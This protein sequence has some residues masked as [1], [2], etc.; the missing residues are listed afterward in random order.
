MRGPAEADLRHTVGRGE[1]VRVVYRLGRCAASGVLTL[2]AATTRP[3]VFVLRRGGA[4]C[5]DGELA[6]RALGARLARCAAEPWLAASFEGG[7]AAYPPGAVNQLPLAGWARTHIEGRFDG[8]IAEALVR[9]LDGRRLTLRPELA[10]DPTDDADRRMLAAMAQPRRLDQI[11]PLARAPRFRMLGFLHLLR[12]VGA[13]DVEAPARVAS[14]TAGAGA[15]GAPASASTSRSTSA[16]TAGATRASTSRPTGGAPSASTSQATGASTGRPT[17]ASPGPPARGVDP[18][19][20]AAMRVLG[21]DGIADELDVKRAYRRLART[22]HPDLQPGADEQRRRVLERRFA[23][24]TA[25]YEA[26]V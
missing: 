18:R 22:L 24:L 4:L 9:E 17:G 1:L 14:A 2:A 5:P 15:P 20:A 25:A 23:E 19:R 11:W 13:L 21:L 7:V 6:R 26:L 3:E 8:A 16:S 12:S 10:P